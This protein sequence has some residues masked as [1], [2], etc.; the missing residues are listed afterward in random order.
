LPRVGSVPAPRRLSGQCF[1]SPRQLHIPTRYL[2]TFVNRRYVRDKVLTHAVLQGYDTLLMKGQY[3]VVVLFLEVSFADV[4]V[5]VHPAKYEIRF[6]RQADVHE[7]VATAVRQAL[8]REAKGPLPQ[9]Q[10][11]TQAAFTGVRE[12]AT[13]WTGFTA[14]RQDVPTGQ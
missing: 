2:Y 1:L 13:P 14:K 12:S 5:N 11:F 3:P 7:A 6:R 4:D 9:F 10:D 8:Q